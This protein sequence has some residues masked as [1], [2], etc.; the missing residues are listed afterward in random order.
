MFKHSVFLYPHFSRFPV[1]THFAVIM[2]NVHT[3]AR[4]NLPPLSYIK[5]VGNTKPSILYVG[6]FMSIKTGGKQDRLAARFA[7]QLG[8]SFVCFDYTDK[9]ESVWPDKS[10]ERMWSFEQWKQDALTIFD[11]VTE[12]PQVGLGVC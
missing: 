11:T 2:T 10:K 3:I 7:K 9:G 8:H 1:H 5:I 6:G 12:G 4:A